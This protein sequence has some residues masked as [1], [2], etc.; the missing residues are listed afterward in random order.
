MLV[1]GCRT[2]SPWKETALGEGRYSIDVPHVTSI[3]G[4]TNNP[5]VWVYE[6]GRMRIDAP[7]PYGSA[8]AEIWIQWENGDIYGHFTPSNGTQELRFQLNCDGTNV[9]FTTDDK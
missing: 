1:T 6:C 3:V 8:S 4:A 7:S 2:R 9:Q 5:T